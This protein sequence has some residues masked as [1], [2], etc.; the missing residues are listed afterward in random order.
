MRPVRNLLE[1]GFADPLALGQPWQ[2]LRNAVLTIGNITGCYFAHGALRECDKWPWK[3]LDGDL[4]ENPQALRAMATP[5]SNPLTMK[6]WDLLQSC[7]DAECISFDSIVAACELLLQLPWT[8]LGSE[9]VHGSAALFKREHPD[10]SMMTMLARSFLHS[11]RAL[12]RRP[13]KGPVRRQVD[14]LQRHIDRLSERMVQKAGPSQVLFKQLADAAKA[15]MGV[16]SLSIDARK[17]LM[18][19]ANEEF[20]QL[21]QEELGTLRKQTQMLHVRQAS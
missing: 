4:R 12:W 15:R 17:Q 7:E 16:E 18:A 20:R 1:L 9:Q 11:I 19:R 8:S 6:I 3:L 21:T 5:P 10:Y 13:E 2:E 14:Q